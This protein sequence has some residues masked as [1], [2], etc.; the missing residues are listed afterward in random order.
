MPLS[1]LGYDATTAGA[2]QLKIIRNIIVL[3]RV[4]VEKSEENGIGLRPQATGLRPQATGYRLQQKNLFPRTSGITSA[5]GINQSGIVI[6]NYFSSTVN[7]VALT[8]RFL[9]HTPL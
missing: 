5:L 6:G 9:W 2:R 1:G 8:V 4:A 3:M 7:A